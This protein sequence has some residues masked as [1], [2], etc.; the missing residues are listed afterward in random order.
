[1]ARIFSIFSTVWCPKDTERVRVA[2]VCIYISISV[3]GLLTHTHTLSLSPHTH[4]YKNT[5]SHKKNLGAITGRHSRRHLYAEFFK[6]WFR[7]LARPPFS[8]VVRYCRAASG[9][10][11]SA[12]DHVL[13]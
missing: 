4:V 13:T 3:R 7:H 11:A 10:R 9:C 6:A 12:S 2:C 5:H 8:P 1:V